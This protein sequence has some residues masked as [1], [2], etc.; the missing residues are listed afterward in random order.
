[1]KYY[2]III[3]MLIAVGCDN[4]N[5]AYTFGCTDQQACNYNPNANVSDNSTCEYSDAYDTCC[6]LVQQDEC[7]ICDGNGIS[8]GECDCDGNIL[9]E[10][11]ICN[12]NGISDGECDCQAS[13]LDCEG[14]C[15][16]D[17]LE[18]C[19]GICNGDAEED[20]CGICQGDGTSCNGCDGVAN[21]GLEFDECGV[22]DGPGIESWACDCLGNTLDCQGI[23]GGNAQF[24]ECGICNENPLDD[25]TNCE[26]QWEEVWTDNFNESINIQDNW[27]FEVWSPYTV[28]NELQAY[29]ASTNNAYI[30]N[31]NLV[32]KALRENLDLNNDGTPDTEYTSARL[33]TQNKRFY[34][35]ENNCGSCDG[36][37]IKVEVR[38]KLPTGVGT[39]PA[40]WMMPNNSEYGSWPNSGEIDIMEHV[41]YDS[42]VI[43]SS[44]HNATNSGSLGGTNQTA[45]Q[46]ISNVE[47]NY[48]TYGLIWSNDEI[49]TFIDNEDNIVLDYNNSEESGY[50][51]WPYNKDFFIILNLAIGGTWGGINGI[52][53]DAFP[54]YMYIDYVKVSEL[55][56]AN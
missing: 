36:G 32:I 41:G 54:Q 43:H 37:K 12:G 48:H 51:L 4:P 28:N 46:T 33:T 11:G 29:T 34:V 5:E 18:D 17:A 26:L 3:I 23:C 47:E 21:S 55:R 8:D 19:L 30:E 15:G 40:I 45:Y 25:C 53:N 2:L 20:S 49:I 1:M 42:N 31:G 24:D 44:V 9:D 27:N 7:G 52:D 10:C 13:T 56:C 16:G 50:E 35:Y 6:L 14:V 39:W 22:C 38:A